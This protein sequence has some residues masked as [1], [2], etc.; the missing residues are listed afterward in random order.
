M[1]VMLA[2]AV[3]GTPTLSAFA[4]R[5]H[6]TCTAKH[7]DCGKV[8]TLTT[9]CCGEEQSSSSDSTPVQS[10]VEVRADLVSVPAVPSALEAAMTPYAQVAIHTSPPH[11]IL[12]RP[13]LFSSLL[14]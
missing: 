5:A 2:V 8:S 3:L 13:T 9:C 7:H 11:P 14:I 12:D 1:S 6:P 4:L 10:R